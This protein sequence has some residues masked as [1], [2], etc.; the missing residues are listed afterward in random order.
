MRALI[1]ASLVLLPALAHADLTPEDLVARWE[2]SFDTT[3][4]AEPLADGDGLRLSEVVL[5]V[6]PELRINL[7]ELVLRSEGDGVRIVPS[8]TARLSMPGSD[9]PE[10]ELRGLADADIVAREGAGA[11]DYDFAL[12]DLAFA[13]IGA[14][15]P[16]TGT[17]ASFEGRSVSDGDRSDIT[18]TGAGLAI[19][20]GAGETWRTTMAEIA[21]TGQGPLDPEADGPLA[22]TAEIRDTVSSALSPGSAE[23]AVERIRFTLDEADGTSMANTAL[24][25]WTVSA[26]PPGGE[27]PPAR[28][29]LDALTYDLTMPAGDAAGGPFEAQ[30]SF[31]GLVPD[32]A[33]RAR[34]DPEGSLT[35]DRISLD[36]SLSGELAEDAPFEAPPEA[37]RIE[38]LS[39]DVFGAA[40]TGDG[41]FS[42][43]GGGTLPTGTARFTLTGIDTVLSTLLQSGALDP[44][45]AMG[46]QVGLGF[47]TRP[48]G[49]DT[50][51]IDLAIEEGGRLLLNGQ[52]LPFAP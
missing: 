47:L 31:D 15:T 24:T 44:G 12:T 42:G 5:P 20:G 9:Q 1:A 36:L 49:P 6:D 23:V 43:G 39:L 13:T 17:M 21:L 4:A 19:E 10:I 51:S 16:A 30:L 50:R 29:T 8:D 46:A 7:P 52:P 3:L 37:L 48:T 35:S 28:L 40:L 14:E 26:P 34:I 18:A 32:E 41:A 45:T 11:S 25:G 2:D 22:A 33:T 38:A 27:G